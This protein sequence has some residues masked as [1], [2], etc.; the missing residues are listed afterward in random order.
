M[1]LQFDDLTVGDLCLLRSNAIQI[2]IDTQVTNRFE[3]ITDA[4]LSC[5]RSKGYNIVNQPPFKAL[6]QKITP[7]DSNAHSPEYI[8]EC[9]F[10][11]LE[12]VKDE[13]REPTW[14]SPKPSWYTPYSNAKKPWMF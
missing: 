5:I 1:S 7:K 13:N 3:A 10:A 4:T 2:L 12:I 11:L 14:S 6:V 8:V 9:I